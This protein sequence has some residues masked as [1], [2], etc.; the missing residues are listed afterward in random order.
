[1][2]K[3]KKGK[4]VTARIKLQCPAGQAN[5][6]PPWVRPWVNTASTLWISASSFNERTKDQQGPYH[7]RLVIT[8]FEDRSFSFITKSPPAPCSIKRAAKLAKASGE[9]NRTR[10][11]GDAGT[12]RRDCNNQENDL[13]AADMDAGGA[14]AR[15]ARPEAWAFW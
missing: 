4:N 5:P 8:V 11:F 9:P 2:A 7:F 6:A 3:G 10:W 14:H 15:G 13:N 1:M 12:A